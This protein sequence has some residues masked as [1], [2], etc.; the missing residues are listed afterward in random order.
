MRDEAE[1]IRMLVREI[2]RAKTLLFVNNSREA[3]D[4]LR[5]AMATLRNQYGYEEETY[6]LS[7]E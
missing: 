1:A 4:I 5:D 2:E 6:D 7:E 3:Y